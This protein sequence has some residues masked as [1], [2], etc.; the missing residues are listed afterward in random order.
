MMQARLR[1]RGTPE[2]SFSVF[3]GRFTHPGAFP[4]SHISQKT[5]FTMLCSPYG[6]LLVDYVCKLENIDEGMK[7]VTKKLGLPNLK[8]PKKNTTKEVSLL[9]HYTG[10]MIKKVNEIFEDDFSFLPYEKR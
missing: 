5:Q 7:V 6:G 8:I 10:S 4:F 9:E 2:R 1:S 3:T